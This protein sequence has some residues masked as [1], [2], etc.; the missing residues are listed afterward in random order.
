MAAKIYPFVSQPGIRRDGTSFASPYW[1]DGQ[2]VRW[3]RGLPR[4][5]GGYKYIENNSNVP[6]GIFV[7]PISR[8]FNVY[9]ATFDSLSYFPI[10]QN[11]NVLG[12]RIDRTPVTLNPNVNNV[13]SFDIMYSSTVQHSVP[14]GSVIFAH[15]PP[16]LSSIDSSVETPI[17]FGDTYA[18]TP[19]VPLGISASG[20][21]CVLHPYLFIFSNT[22]NVKWSV[23]NNPGTILGEARISSQKVV[24]CKQTRGGNSAPAGILWSLDSVIRVTQAGLGSSVE[25][26]FDTISDESSILSSRSVVEYDSKFYWCGIDRFLA[27]NGTVIEIQNNMNQN[28]FFNNLNFSQRQKIWGTKVPE[29]GEI[30]WHYPSGNNTECDRAIIFNVREN[31]W[32]DSESRRSCGY[33]NQVFADPIWCSSFADTDISNQYGVWIHESGLN[34]NVNN[35]LTAIPSWIETGDIS[36]CAIGPTGAW[37]GTEKQ[38]E[39]FRFEPDFIQSG[40]MTIIVKGKQYARSPSINSTP[41]VFSPTTEKIDFLEQR[42]EM[43]LRFMSNVIDGDYQMGQSLIT[44]Y[45]G[46]GR[47]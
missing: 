37:T 21:I 30:W 42:R 10:D 23:A 3:Q 46:D 14:V 41:K 32:Y 35:V 31:T 8:N 7:I 15:A 25:F 13:W 39:L 11:G 9:T 5:M 44:L 18:N 4:K 19:L 28:F 17:Y 24:A 43:R 36:Y 2:W 20:G 22:G 45:V 12:P 29:F 26:R 6:R 34:R 40:D 33:F 1:T 27:Y 16:N 47:P 38:V